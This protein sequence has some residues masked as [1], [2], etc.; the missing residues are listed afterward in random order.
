MAL[1]RGITFFDTANVYGNGH[2]E[3]LIGEAFAHCRDRVVIATK[4]GML[5]SFSAMDFTPIALRASL[6]GSLRRLK[7]DYVD[8]FQLHNPVLDTI[9]PPSEVADLLLRLRDEGKI[10][11]FG[12][13]T[14]SPDEAL[15]FI[16]APGMAAAQVNFNLLDW[17]AVDCGFLSGAKD[18]G[19]G[20]IA[21]TPLAFGFLSGQIK[22]DETFLPEDHRSRWSRER[23][24][25]WVG[26]A[27]E[28]FAELAA[29]GYCVSH[30]ESALQFCLS[31]EGISVVIP[32]MLTPQEVIENTSIGA[33]KRLPLDQ[34][35]RL[36]RV[37]RRH[38]A[39]LTA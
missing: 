12:V 26:A 25:V 5:P 23:V 35:G 11:A 18:A 38:E 14:K 19:I 21:R 6:E 9:L 13:S 16:G 27:D 28:I 37:Y 17:R 32:G 3:E 33:T 10:R 7:T 36:E 2:S 34:L 1:D 29:G 39:R 15:E 4:A 30:V 20:V 24:E 22:R 8:V 31:F